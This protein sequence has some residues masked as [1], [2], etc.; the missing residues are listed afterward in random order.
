VNIEGIIIAAAVIG[1]IALAIGLLLGIA[2]E[3][4]KVE[5]DEKEL[6]V[7]DLLPG[8]NCGACGFAGCDALA[9][10]IASGDASNMACPVNTSENNNK[11]GEVMGVSGEAT[12]REVAFVKCAGTCDKT[13]VK[14]NYFGIQ[15]CKKAV[16]APGKG[17]KKCEYGCMGYGSCVKVCEFDAIHIVEGIALVDKEKC[18]ACKLC[19][20]QC[21][22]NLIEMIPYKATQVVR[23]S[24][25]DKGK[26]V[27]AACSIG[28]IGCKIC[29]RQCEFDAIKVIDNLAYIDQSKC[30]GCN[31]CAEKCPTKVILSEIIAEAK[32]V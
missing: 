12:E 11:I 32:A 18:K 19:V 25:K 23:C 8:N 4:F 24:S 5:V 31:K 7:R 16:L 26:D 1:L 13:K 22:N 30:T 9:K 10:A 17:G 27:K 14:Y 28:C 20:A 3:K 2:G 15:D 21:P 6:I 29:E